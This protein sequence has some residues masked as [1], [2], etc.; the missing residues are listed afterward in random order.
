MR[1]NGLGAPVTLVPLN[2][3]ERA[4]TKTEGKPVESST[5]KSK[6]G[7]VFIAINLA[8]SKPNAEKRNKISGN[9][10]G[11]TTAKL[12]TVQAIRLNTTLAANLK[13]G[14]LLE[15]SQRCQRSAT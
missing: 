7:I 6:N 2:K 14:R 15:W 1:L 3:K 8:T 5:Q 9:R 11:K 13:N 12:T 10:P 4:Q